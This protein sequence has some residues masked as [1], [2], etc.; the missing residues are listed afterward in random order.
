[1]GIGLAFA[2]GGL[3]CVAHI[4]AL[5][6]LEDLNIKVDYISGTSSGSFIAILYAMKFTI[7]E[8]KEIVG[9]YYGVFTKF[10]KM[11]FIKAAS[12][13]IL[14]GEAQIGG[15]TDGYKIESFVQNVAKLRGYEKMSDL[16]IPIAIATVDTISTNECIFLSRTI[17]DDPPKGVEYIYDA[18][19]GIA[20]RASASFPG[21]FTTC[22]YR[23]YN[24]IDGGTKDNL[25]VKI[26]KSMGAEKTI[27]FSFKLDEYKPTENLMNILLRTCD[28]FSQKDV[29]EARKLVD[30]DV[31]IDANGTSLLTIDDMNKCYQTG[32]DAVMQKLGK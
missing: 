13:L 1:M 26:L 3:K 15:L 11:P 21:I 22:D 10:S 8:I 18:P 23:K 32:Y 30:V 20:V 27:S 14:H 6:A 29:E 2:G 17:K 5:K 31:E 7:D 19:I 25:P 4:G 24:F 9:N 16:D 28:I 12:T